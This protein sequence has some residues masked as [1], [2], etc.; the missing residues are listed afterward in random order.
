MEI[1]L[2]TQSDF[3]HSNVL[4]KN[5]IWG[6][7]QDF[8]SVDLHPKEGVSALLQRDIVKEVRDAGV[9]EVVQQRNGSIVN[10]IKNI[11]VGRIVR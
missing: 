3:R 6:V 4:R 2:W 7:K 8:P 11:K 5:Q 1:G 10:H 9:R